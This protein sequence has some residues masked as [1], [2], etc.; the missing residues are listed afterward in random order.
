MASFIV[1]MSPR[2]DRRCLAEEALDRAEQRVGRLHVRDVAAMLEHHEACIGKRAGKRLGSLERNRVVTPMQNQHGTIYLFDALQEVEVT[3][4]FPDLLL[5]ATYD[6]E[7][8]QVPGAPRV[9]EVPRDRKLEGA[10]AVGVRIALSQ[11]RLRQ[12]LPEL[13]HGGAPLPLGEIRLEER[14]KGARRRSGVDEDETRRPRPG[15]FLLERRDRVQ[16]RQQP[17]PGIADDRQRLSR[18]LACDE[19]EVGDVRLPGDRRTILGL[20]LPAASLV[21][22][23]QLVPLA[24][25]EHLRKEI[26]VVRARSAM[27]DEQPRR[28]RAAVRGP[29]EGDRR[30]FREAGGARSGYGRHE[31]ENNAMMNEE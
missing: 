6:A 25:R 31:L 19:G 30:R 2:R 5:D 27:Q 26:V 7:R 21:V 24:Q 16:Q 17:A 14:A 13:L 11:P 18:E 20:R 8:G 29:V 4:T 22:E 3:K 28:D 9:G 12:L 10:L 1:R 15:L 23:D